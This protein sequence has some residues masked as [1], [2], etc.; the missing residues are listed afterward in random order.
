M[1]VGEAIVMGA[2]K[3]PDGIHEV[4]LRAICSSDCERANVRGAGQCLPVNLERGGRGSVAR[5][6]TVTVPDDP[7]LA[8]GAKVLVEFFYPGEQAGIH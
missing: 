3:R 8:L 7:E 4:H 6:F 1:E 5:A 2:S